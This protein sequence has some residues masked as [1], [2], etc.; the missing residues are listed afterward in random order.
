MREIVLDTETT[1]LNPEEGHRIVEIGCIE[2]V[3]RVKT[4]RFFHRYVNPERDMPEQAFNVHG[5]SSE[6]LQDKPLFVDIAGEF[7]EFIKD[8]RLIIHNAK[9]DLKFLNHELLLV[10]HSQIISHEIIDTLLLARKK[11]P[12][13]PANLDALCRKFNIDLTKRSKHGALLDSELLAEVY[14]G[15]T[16]G[17]QSTLFTEKKIEDISKLALVSKGELRKTRDFAISQEE[18]SLHREFIDKI[19]NP[20]WSKLEQ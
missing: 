18:E 13:S 4:G 5:I 9:F 15:L 8:A 2:M 10:K 7:V 14:I 11:F 3:N 16:G 20:I 17:I 6:F 19:K 1:G 12:G